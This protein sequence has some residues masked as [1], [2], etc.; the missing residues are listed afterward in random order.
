MPAAVADGTT[1][2]GVPDRAPRRTGPPARPAARG[3]AR[4]AGAGHAQRRARR[5][6][7][8]RRAGWPTRARRWPPSRSSP[9]RSASPGRRCASSATTSATSRAASRS[10]AW[11]SSRTASRGRASTAGSGSRPCRAP[12]TSPATRRCCAAGSG[13]HGPGEEGSEEERRWAMPDLVIVDG[14]KGQVSAAK[15]VL[16]EL[17]LHDL[18]LAGL[19][20]EREELFLPGRPTRSCCRRRPRAVPRPAAARRGAP[21]RDHLP[22]RPA[23]QRDRP[24][25][26]RRPAG[27]RAEAQARA[28]QGVRLDQ[29]GA[30]GAGRADRRGAGHRPRRWP[31]G[32]R[33]RSRPE[34]ARPSGGRADVPCNIP[35]RCEEPAPS[36]SSSSACSP[37]SIDF[38]PDLRLPDSAS[39]DR[40]GDRSRPS[41]ASTS[42]A[43]C[44]SS[45][46]RCRSR[47]R[48]A[49]RPG[50]MARHQG[51]HRA[52]R[53]HDRRLGAG[54]R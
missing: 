27:R 43:A 26:V 38:F 51:H 16:D 1:I 41:S 45:T 8:S 54:R 50:D 15:E 21:V 52:A 22:P 48:G 44:G 20:K 10:A 23:R 6:P 33:P 42:R 25:G 29:A 37:C 46:R 32:S 35:P 19:A 34:R 17:G 47:R 5:S 7:A 40:R 4:A 24:L 2:R 14:G 12:T 28:A 9:T 3:E 49:R 36:S 11:S 39:A 30:R 31:S 13:A 53:E 18:P